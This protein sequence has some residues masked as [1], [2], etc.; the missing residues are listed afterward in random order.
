MR[1]LKKNLHRIVQLNRMSKQIPWQR[2]Q[3][4]LPDVHQRCVCVHCTDCVCSL[5]T[6]APL[7]TTTIHS[8]RWQRS[9]VPSSSQDT[10]ALTHFDTNSRAVITL[11]PPGA[12]CRRSPLLGS[13]RTDRNSKSKHGVKIKLGEYVSM[14]VFL[15]VYGSTALRHS[16]AKSVP[17]T[18]SPPTHTSASPVPAATQTSRH[19]LKLHLSQHCWFQLRQTCS[20][21]P[22]PKSAPPKPQECAGQSL[23]HASFTQQIIFR[24][25]GGRI[26]LISYLGFR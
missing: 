1:A 21:D 3:R 4:Y 9:T 20:S 23:Q 17:E 11:D 6:T 26:S 2:H 12:A 18:R 15:S 7:F 10:H 8:G 16:S 5:S 14:C 25:S 24:K 22:E 13:S 19:R